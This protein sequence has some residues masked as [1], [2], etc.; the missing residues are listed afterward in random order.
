MAATRKGERTGSEEACIKPC[1]EQEQQMGQTVLQNDVT[2]AGYG[3]QACGMRPQ[4]CGA[5][6][7]GPRVKGR[8]D[9]ENAETI[10][11]PEIPTYRPSEAE[12]REGLH[13][14][15]ERVRPDAEKYG[16]IR[17]VPPE[18]KRAA[19]GEPATKFKTRVQAINEL[20]SR[21]PGP[22]GHNRKERKK[23]KRAHPPEGD[24][25]RGE[26]SGEERHEPYGTPY[27]FPDGPT[28]TVSELREY[29]DYFMR[30]HFRDERGNP[31]RKLTVRQLEGE[32]WRIV[33][34][35]DEDEPVEVIYGA[36]IP[37]NEAG[38]CFQGANDESDQEPPIEQWSVQATNA[39]ALSLV[40]HTKGATG[41]SKPW[42]YFGSA[43]T[44]F[45]WH[46]ED[47]HLFSVNCL[48][49]GAPKVWYVVPAEYG[50]EFEQAMRK[51]LG[52]LFD[53]QPDLLQSLV[54]HLSPEKLKGEGVPVFRAVQEAGNYIITFPFAYHGGFNTSYNVAEA[55]NFAP[56]RWAFPCNLPS[57][58]MLFQQQRVVWCGQL[59]A[60][61]RSERALASAT[62]RWGGGRRSLLTGSLWRWLSRAKSGRHRAGLQLRWH[63]SLR[64]E[65]ARRRRQGRVPWRSTHPEESPSCPRVATAPTWRTQGALYAGAIATCRE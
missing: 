38:S 8:W 33:E 54:T 40:R 43:L 63:Q 21:P 30:W 25:D 65:F 36:D 37:T 47:H 13:S 28:L 61:L 48:T 32:F 20:Q 11:V 22:Y 45:C 41:I 1:F 64:G 29:A 31:P 5:C 2:E 49:A 12:F 52:T 59:A 9:P 23:R 51:H 19:V 50:K 3:C 35:H 44:A 26:S 34:R 60:G 7:P 15:V 56:P 62:H 14:F 55:V 10:D 27:G 57:M 53:Y 39:D 46:V 58:L 24:D 6:I 18:S 16:A 4:G 42:L 17:V